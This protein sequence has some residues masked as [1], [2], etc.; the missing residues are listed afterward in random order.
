MIGQGTANRLATL[1]ITDLYGVA[2]CPEKIL[3][4]MFGVNAEYLIDHAWGKDYLKI[5][6]IKM[7]IS[8]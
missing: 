7:R 6:T 4:K 3:Y 5:I 2:H 1:G 8:L